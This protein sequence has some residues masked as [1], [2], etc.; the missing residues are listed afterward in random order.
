VP[1][2][3]TLAIT[4]LRLTGELLR[5]SPRSSTVTPGRRRAVGI[6]WLIPVFGVWFALPRGRRARRRPA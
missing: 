1:A 4:M 2:L 6:V 3:V 5:W